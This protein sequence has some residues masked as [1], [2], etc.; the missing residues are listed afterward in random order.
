M[1]GKITED[2]NIYLKRDDMSHEIT[3]DEFIA[4]AKASQLVKK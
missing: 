2:I 4:K 3:K 1:Y